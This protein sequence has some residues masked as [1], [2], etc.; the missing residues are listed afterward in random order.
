MPLTGLRVIDLS[1]IIAGPFCAQLLGDMGAEVIKIETPNKGDPVRAQGAIRDG[2]SWYY[3]FY[4]RNKK[5]L[6]L[7]LR[8]AEGKAILSDVI[9]TCD[10]LVENFRPGVME[11]MGFGYGH[12]KQLKPDII[13]CSITG[14]GNSGPYKDRPAVD[15]IAQAMSGFMS[16]N[17]NEGEETLRA[18]IP[19]SDMVA[20]LYAAFGIMGALAHRAKTG[21]GQEVQSSLVDGLVSMLSF[22]ASNYLASGRLP[23]RPGND[24]PLVAPYGLFRCSDGEVAIAPSN[25][26]MY[27]KFLSALGLEHLQHVAEFATNELRMAN[28]EKIRAV[29][30]EV[31]E[32]KPKSH[33]IEHLNKAGVPCGTVMNLA[34]V[35]ADEQVRHQEMVLDVSHPGNRVVKLLGF[36]VKLSRTPCRVARHAPDLGE[37]TDEILSGMGLSREKIDELRHLGVV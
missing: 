17:G 35:F 5:S 16:V 25:D 3:A 27:S 32:R 11:E 31:I 21:Q 19:I 33:W 13:Y 9:R 34:E 8:S 28:K 6:T 23:V 22:M 15:F 2:M 36:P 14:Y 10:V 20:G 18:G 12:L 26:Y 37:H 30:Q 4:N 29:I 7:N 1:R 24:H